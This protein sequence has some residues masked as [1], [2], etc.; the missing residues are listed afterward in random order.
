MEDIGIG[1]PS[2]L[3][4]NIEKPIIVIDGD[5]L[6]ADGV[7]ANGDGV[8]DG[9][10]QV[11]ARLNPDLIHFGENGEIYLEQKFDINVTSTNAL[12]STN[13][14]VQG[15]DR[16]VTLDFGNIDNLPFTIGVTGRTEEEVRDRIIL[17]IRSLWSNPVTIFDGPQIDNNQTGGNSFTLS[18]LNMSVSSNNPS[19]LSVRHLSNMLIN[20]SAFTRATPLILPEPVIHGFSEIAINGVPNIASNGRPILQSIPESLSDDIYIYNSNSL[21]NRRVSLSKFSFPTNYLQGT[22]MPSHRFPSI[23]GNGRYLFFSSDSGGLGGLI[24]DN[25]NQSPVPANDNGRRD[26]FLVDLKDNSLPVTNYTLILLK[27]S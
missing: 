23:S 16:N 7:D 11:D 9:D 10:G 17:L 20:G 6:D 5:G 24:F 1:Y 19:A 3:F 2:N 4:D 21:S 15:Y 18:G 25:S 26:I 22:N 14:L 27:T 12:L 8:L 13:L